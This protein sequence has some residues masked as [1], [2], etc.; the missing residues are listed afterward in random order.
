MFS[1]SLSLSLPFSLSLSLALSLSF[2]LSFVCFCCSSFLSPPLSIIVIVLHS[3]YS[4][5]FIWG[6]AAPSF[7]LF[8]SSFK[9]H[10]KLQFKKQTKNH[11][12]PNLVKMDSV[13]LTQSCVS[14][15][16]SDQMYWELGKTRLD[17]INSLLIYYLAVYR[18]YGLL[19]VLKICWL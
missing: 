13:T 3:L 16:I 8:I 19:A 7:F 15:K 17:I 6:K 10:M 18:F 12:E 11:T 9:F 14:P 4:Y 1:L 2:S 5:F